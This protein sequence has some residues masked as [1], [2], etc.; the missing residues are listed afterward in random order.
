MLVYDVHERETF[1]DLA[2]WLEDVRAY[3][4]PDAVVL[5]VGN[6]CD[7]RGER[8]AVPEDEARDWAERHGCT[9][10]QA[11]AKNNVMVEEAFS[12]LVR[13]YVESPG[14]LRPRLTARI[15]PRIDPATLS[16]AMPAGKS[17]SSLC[18]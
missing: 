13:L 15:N 18:C 3:A 4:H 5:V 12:T 14:H 16:C 9:F 10:L 8:M 7:T 17:S 6:K 2:R 11:S 1:T